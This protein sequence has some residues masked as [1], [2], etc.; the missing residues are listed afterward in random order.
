MEPAEEPTEGT[1]GRLVEILERL[2]TDRG[3]EANREQFKAPQFDGRGDVEYFIQH[4]QE[5]RR[6]PWLTSGDPEP[7]C[8]T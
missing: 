4:F 6:W 2:W 8:C 7:P 3:P 1:L 5:V